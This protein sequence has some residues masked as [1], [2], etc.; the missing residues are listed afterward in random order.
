[1]PSTKSLRFRD[2]HS[3]QTI[4]V[5]KESRGR[6][7]SPLV[8]S[9]EAKN[10]VL[11][12]KARKAPFPC[13]P[14]E[15]HFLRSPFASTGWAPKVS[16]GR[17]ESPLVASAEAKSSEKQKKKVKA[18]SLAFRKR[19]I[20]LWSPSASTGWAPKVSKGRPESPLVASAEAKAPEKQEKKVKAL[21]L[22]LH[23][24]SVSCGRFRP[25]AGGRGTFPAR[26][27]TQ[28]APGA[29]KGC[30]SHGRPRTPRC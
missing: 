29:A 26:E 30:M 15:I 13:L 22:A 5:P 9:A 19:S 16:K 20:F 17:P 10:S 8:S 12:E 2:S 27:S 3:P 23:K 21:S 24:K 11:Q 25:P 18:L 4:R 7:E 1:M 6:P 14:Q 28:R